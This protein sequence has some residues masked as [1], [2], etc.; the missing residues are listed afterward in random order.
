MAPKLV[1]KFKT[2]AKRNLGSSSS[3]GSIIGVRFLT[4]KC[5]EAYET[6]NKYRPIW[7]EREIVLSGLDPSICRNYG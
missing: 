3:S 5:E 1:G 4:E 2:K 7:G 6:L